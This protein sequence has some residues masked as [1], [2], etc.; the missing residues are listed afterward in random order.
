[1]LTSK[2]SDKREKE[3]KL[4]S[5]Q[6]IKK[7]ITFCIICVIFY[8]IYIVYSISSN[9]KIPELEIPSEPIKAN[10]IQQSLLTGESLYK[11]DKNSLKHKKTT[12]L[13]TNTGCYVI[14]NF[15]VS[16]KPFNILRENNK[17]EQV[18]WFILMNEAYCLSEDN[19]FDYTHIT[20]IAIEKEDP[21]NLEDK[22][23]F[24]IYINWE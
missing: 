15:V 20:G 17:K 11:I 5:K 24:D 18:N 7:T 13:R 3:K 10:Q 2:N 9:L 23:V 14:G 6:N 22:N 4:E 12:I 8:F 16:N 21:N 1:M 19:K